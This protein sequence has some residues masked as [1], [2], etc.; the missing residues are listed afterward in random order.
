MTYLVLLAVA[1]ALLLSYPK[2]ELHILLNSHHTPFGDVFFRCY[3]TLA[4]WPLYVLAFVPLLFHRRMWT[5]LFAASEI[6][7][8]ITVQIIKGVWNMPRPMAFFN[9]EIANFLP[10]VEGVHLHHHHSFPSGHTSTFFVFFTCCAL[11]LIKE[12]RRQGEQGD[13]ASQKTAKKRL[14][15]V[16]SLVVIVLLAALGGYSRIYLSQHFLI[17]VF[18]GSIIGTTVTCL[19]FRYFVKKN[20]FKQ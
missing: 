1:A 13:K 3:S 9:D 6:V 20:L 10:V 12:T 16:L 17:D 11:I 8:A 4:E 19:V 18:V 7:A 15:S 2:G 5:A 14:F